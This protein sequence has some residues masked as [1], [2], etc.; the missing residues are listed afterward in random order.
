[1]HAFD[2]LGDPVRRRVLEVLAK[3]EQ[4]SGEIVSI[5]ELEFNISQSAVSQ[6]L[7]I[8]RENGFAAVRNEGTRRV[9]SL[10]TTSMQE[11]DEWLEQFRGFWKNKLEALAT[12]VARGKRKRH[13]PRK[14]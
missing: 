7:R 11:V 4:S 3:Q 14:K 8:L 12:E 2:V 1:M 9:Y 10:D 13:G 5:V 6:H